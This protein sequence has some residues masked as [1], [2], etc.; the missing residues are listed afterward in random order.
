MIHAKPHPE[1]SLSSGN[2]ENATCTKKPTQIHDEHF[3]F[4]FA[5]EQNTGAGR[6]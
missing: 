5:T 1:D 4:D 3:I 2:H 6:N